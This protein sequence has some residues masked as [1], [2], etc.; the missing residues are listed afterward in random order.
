M[1][2][3]LYARGVDAPPSDLAFLAA[4]SRNLANPI[5]DRAGGLGPDDAGAGS[6][7]TGRSIS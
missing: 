1:A 4:Q 3:L 6:K 5:G 2:R 7:R